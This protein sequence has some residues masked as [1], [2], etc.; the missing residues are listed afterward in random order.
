[1]EKTQRKKHRHG[2]HNGQQSN[3]KRKTSPQTVMEIMCSTINE[4]GIIETF[5]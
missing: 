1:M 4:I 3:F 2:K 5:I